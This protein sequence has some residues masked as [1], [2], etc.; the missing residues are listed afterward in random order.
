ML[1]FCD[2]LINESKLVKDN[3]VEC[4]IKQMDAFVKKVT[5][6]KQELPIKDETEFTKWLLR[7]TQEDPDGIE[8]TR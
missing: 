3:N 1:E 4:W 2:F 5:N 8:A 7:F 6:N